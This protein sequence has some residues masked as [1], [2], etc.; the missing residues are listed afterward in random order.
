[1]TI[2]S[3]T[4]EHPTRS[5]VIRLSEAQARI[6]GPAGE[7]A[8]RVLQRGSLDVTLSAPQR[9][10]EQSPDE[11]D[12]FYVIIRGRGV[13]FHDGKRDS[14]ESGDLLLVDAGV[15]HQFEDISDDLTVWRI[16]YGTRGGEISTSQSGSGQ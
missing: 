10:I 5:N 9:P 1:M 7:H 6:P 16:F 2:T 3:M 14:F 12:E 4:L 13:L 11:Q 8:V 15:E